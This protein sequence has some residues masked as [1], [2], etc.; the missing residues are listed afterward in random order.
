MNALGFAI[1][2]FRTRKSTAPL[3]RVL[4]EVFRQ[5][6]GLFPY[7][8]EYGSIEAYTY[9]A[10]RPQHNAFPYSKEYGSIEASTI[11]LATEFVCKFPYSKEYGS[12]EAI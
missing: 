8:K 10:N 3:K 9:E 6:L 4:P 12:I 2:G 5:L 1:V 7:S 11:E